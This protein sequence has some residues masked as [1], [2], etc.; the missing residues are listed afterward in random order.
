[1]AGDA[2]RLDA[3]RLDVLRRWGRGLSDDPRDEVR[4]AGRAIAMLIEE[5]EHLHIELWHARDVEPV[6][7][8]RTDDPEAAETVEAPAADAPELPTG[9]DNVPGALLGRVRGLFTGRRAAGT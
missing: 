1:M 6:H 2:E 3:E 5:I 7:A 4:A 8:P 9:V